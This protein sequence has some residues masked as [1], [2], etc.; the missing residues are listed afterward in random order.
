MIPS[1]AMPAG[2]YQLCTLRWIHVGRRAAVRV[3]ASLGVEIVYTDVDFNDVQAGGSGSNESKALGHVK[4]KPLTVTLGI[5]PSTRDRFVFNIFL[6]D[7]DCINGRGG[8]T[9]SGIAKKLF[10]VGTCGT[11]MTAVFPAAAALTTSPMHS[12]L[13][14]RQAPDGGLRRR[15]RE[16]VPLRLDREYNGG[17]NGAKPEGAA[18][19]DGRASRKHN[20]FRIVLSEG[21][22]RFRCPPHFARK[23]LVLVSTAAAPPGYLVF[24]MR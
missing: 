7:D 10:A 2:T 16:R 19:S 11:S 22:R 15:E 8:E 1:A 23:I 21:H 6:D 9:S 24:T 5:P 13:R 4:G 14:R 17:R 12:R 3:S 20:E 18:N